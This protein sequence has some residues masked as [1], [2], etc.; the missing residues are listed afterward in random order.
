MSGPASVVEPETMLRIRVPAST[1]NLGAAFDAVG[2]ALRLYLRLELRRI[3]EGPSRLEFEGKDA[4]LV[5]ADES[6]LIWRVMAETAGRAGRQLP[7]FHL[8]I[9]NEIPITKGLGSSAS[10][11]LAGAAAADRLCGLGLRAQ[12]LLELAAS[13]EG[14]PDNVA[15]SLLGGLVA[16]MG[17][18]RIRCARALFPE[19]WTVVA[20]TPDFELET[21]R[22][23]AALPREIPH[24]DAVFNVQRAAFLMAQI[25]QGRGEGLRQAMEDRL[26]QPYR[27]RLLPGF[28]EILGME[29]SPGLL[30]VALSG[31]GSTVVAFADADAA[32]IGARIQAIF[33]RHGLE[34]EVRLLGADNDGLVCETVRA[35]SGEGCQP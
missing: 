31:A 2:L 1:S 27:S 26:H 33:S 29:D 19:S 14:H 16:S 4:H 22:A 20:V 8:R 11:C 15:P 18:A 5:P 25:I 24:A 32:G 34:S 13:R 28:D 9:V 21:R 17:G 10:A 7:P 12:D 30:G 35:T 6:N 3:G 23:R